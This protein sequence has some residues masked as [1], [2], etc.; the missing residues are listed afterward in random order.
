[1]SQSL[2]GSRLLL[3]V[4][5]IVTMTS[6]ASSS[7]GTKPVA[8]QAS[9]AAAEILLPVPEENK[10]G[11]QMSAELDKEL[12]MHP[13]AEVQAYVRGLGQ[14]VVA[15]ANDVPE[16]ISFTF[17]VVKD[18]E[19]VNAFAI[20]GG[21]IYIYTGLMKLAEDEAEL[22]SVIGHEVAHVTKRHIAQ[23]MV[24]IYGYSA[25]AQL[26]L[27]EDPG[28]LGEIVGGVVTNGLMLKHGRDHERHA[29]T[30]GIR[31]AV[32][33]GYDPHGFV[34]MFERMR[35]VQDGAGADIQAL[36]IFMSH[37]LPQARAD[38]IAQVLT[39]QKSPPT[40]RNLE[41]YAAM[42]AKL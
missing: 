40:T 13:D 12:T 16:G 17:H 33:A 10:L 23:R 18:D 32:G 8:E 5:A 7:G 6:C 34:R 15:A 21:H 3:P 29:D 37:P 31:Y 2:P 19:T 39:Q 4:A 30:H 11:V 42:K 24:G 25:L 20:P 26:A 28:L 27:G 1:M 36:E 35:A 22:V 14:Q 9:E 41:Q 38:R